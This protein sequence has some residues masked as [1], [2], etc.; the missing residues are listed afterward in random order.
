MLLTKECDYGVRAIRALRSGDK[1]TVKDICDK[2]HIPGQYAYKILKKLELA[3]LVKGF[4]GRD[5]G[6]Q[7]IKPLESITLL[8]IV[9]AIDNNLYLN[10]CLREGVECAFKDRR[11]ENVCSV[12]LELDRIQSVLTSELR[13]KTMRDLVSP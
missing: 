9:S 6:Y 2:E 3:R 8:E 5:G 4:R 12:H 11:H 1:M 10:E 7:L 13:R